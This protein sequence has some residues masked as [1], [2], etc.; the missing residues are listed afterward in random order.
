MR[1]LLESDD[2]ETVTVA[3]HDIGEYIMRHPLGRKK[4]EEIEAKEIVLRLLL[5]K[6]PQI[7]REAL[8]TT[9]DLLLKSA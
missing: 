1:H 5:H 9:Q 3:L 7:Q 8:R 6:N 2:E 4:I